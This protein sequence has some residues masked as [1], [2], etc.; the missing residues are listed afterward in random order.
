MEEFVDRAS[1]QALAPSPISKTEP[2]LP[3]DPSQGLRWLFSSVTLLLPRDP[4]STFLSPSQ[5]LQGT[6]A[7]AQTF[8]L[9]PLVPGL[10]GPG[11]RGCQ[12]PPHLR[13]AAAVLLA[14][15]ASPAPGPQTNSISCFPPSPPWTPAFPTSVIAPSRLTGRSQTSPV[16]P[17]IKH[18]LAGLLLQTYRPGTRRPRGLVRAL[19][20]HPTGA[21][22]QRATEQTAAG[23]DTGDLPVH[24]P[25]WPR[26][27]RKKQGTRAAPE[28]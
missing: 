11:C 22:A 27:Q 15:S 7:A 2:R 20:L 13:C 17:R 18:R 10:P 21:G 16:A 1:W 5:G 28:M 24:C 19:G 23:P 4:S 25:R 9:L 26:T 12:R 3:S 8:S 6:P 14:C